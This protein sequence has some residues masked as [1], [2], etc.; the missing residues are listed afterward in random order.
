MPKIVRV[1]IDT[2][3]GFCHPN[4]GLYVK[5]AE[6]ILDLVS[7]LNRGAKV[8]GYPLIGSVDSH[9]PEDKE[10]KAQGGPWPEH[11]VLGTWDWNKP[12]ITLPESFAF[13]A[14]NTGY[15]TIEAVEASV[16]YRLDNAI[17]GIGVYFEKSTYSFLSNNIAT[18]VLLELYAAGY[19]DFEV[20]GV[21]LD[22]CVKASAIGIK[23]LLPEAKVTLLQYACCGVDMKDSVAAVKEMEA[24]G[25][26]VAR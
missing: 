23:E 2:Q 6:Q 11:C 20:Y 24:A 10:F 9:T 16:E 3:N 1:D 4:G 18:L 7:Q 21:A 19:T 14:N 8:M 17:R 26:E 12:E 15:P 5:G 13:V 22:Y 25:V